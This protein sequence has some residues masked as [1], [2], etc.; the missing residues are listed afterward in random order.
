MKRLILSLALLL[1]LPLESLAQVTTIPS[2]SAVVVSLVVPMRFT[3]STQEE[4]SVTL[5]VTEPVMDAQGNTLISSGARAAG[6]LIPSLKKRGAYLSVEKLIVGGRVYRVNAISDLIPSRE[7]VVEKASDRVARICSSIA[8]TAQATWT[9]LDQ[10]NPEK[11]NSPAVLAYTFCSLTQMGP[12][13]TEQIIEM[14][15]SISYITVLSSSL[16]VSMP[17]QSNSVGAEIVPNPS[18]P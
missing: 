17:S 3:L 11:A 14:P 4:A 12:D 2:E 7:V 15:S 1:V 8:K 10:A 9:V 18:R 6:K 16:E 5:N 13:T